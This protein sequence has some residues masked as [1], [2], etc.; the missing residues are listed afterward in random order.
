MADWSDQE[1]NPRVF[2][3]VKKVHDMDDEEFCRFCRLVKKACECGK[4]SY[5]GVP[6]DEAV[7]LATSDAEYRKALRGRDFPI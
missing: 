7:S 3:L 2:N 1:E 6:I 5:G 4:E